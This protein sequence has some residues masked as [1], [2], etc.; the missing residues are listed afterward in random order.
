MDP[1]SI[2]ASSITIAHAS[3][4]SLDFIRETRKAP[5]ELLSLQNEVS[6]LVILLVDLREQLQRIQ[7][8]QDRM[9]P[10]IRML[11][12]LNRSRTRL[13][14]LMGEVSTWA[15]AAADKRVRQ[16]ARHFRILRVGPKSR[17]FGDELRAIRQELSQFAAFFST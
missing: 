8:E 6:D 9:P 16:Q 12:V 17:K 15:S 3:R 7:D 1:L 2:I 13:D 11:D 4:R 5:H 10:T 14:Q